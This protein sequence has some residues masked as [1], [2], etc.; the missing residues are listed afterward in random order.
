MKRVSW[1]SPQ[2]GTANGFGY[3]AVSL[4]EALNRKGIAMDHTMGEGPHRNNKVHISWVQPE[5]YE[6]EKDQYK[7]GYTPWESTELPKSWP[8]YMN[9]MDEIW[10][11]S[12]FCADLFRSD[13]QIN[14]PIHIVPHGVNPEHWPITKREWNKRARFVFLH[15]GGPTERKGAQKVV[16][17]FIDLFDGDNRFWLHLKT[18]GY[19]ECRYWDRGA[20]KS[21]ADHPQIFIYPNEMPVEQLYRMYSNANCMVYPSNGEGFGLIPFQAIASGLPTIV[22]NGTAMADYAHLSMPLKFAW[23]EGN[24]VH[25]GNWCDPDT[26]HLRYLMQHVVDNYEQESESVLDGANWLHQNQ[27]WDHVADQVVDLIGDKL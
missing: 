16:D 1:Y 5:W 10:T 24:G 25:L 19:T 7:I 26:E 23:T 18:N 20:F 6:G 21:A 11:P 12:R 3:A 14:R 9:E 4:I 27:T 22:T 8:R 17:A 2:I 13:E 15:V